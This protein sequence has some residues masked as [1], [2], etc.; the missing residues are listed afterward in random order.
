VRRQPPPDSAPR[1]AQATAVPLW[2]VAGR[3]LLRLLLA[4]VA[5]TALVSSAIGQLA[6]S[7]LSRSLS[8]GFYVVGCGTLV[9]GFALAVRGPVRLGKG[10]Q[11]GFRV[12]TRDER[13]DAIADSALLVVLAIALLVLGVLADTRYPLL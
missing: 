12:V 8:V 7:P 9:L 1:A 2:A 4:S 13:D 6:G 11:R 5:G 3:R 10:E